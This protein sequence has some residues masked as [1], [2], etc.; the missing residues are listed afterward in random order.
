MEIQAADIGVPSTAYS[1]DPDYVY[2][3]YY[4]NP[5]CDALMEDGLTTVVIY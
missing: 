4:Y 1:T 5:D 2:E 3:D